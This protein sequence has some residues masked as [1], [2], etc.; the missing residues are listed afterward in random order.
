MELPKVSEESFTE[1]KGIIRVEAVTNDARCIWRETPLRDVGIDGQI[2][3]VND[4][5]RATGRIV[6]TQVKSG[7]SYFR[8]ATDDYVPYY[9]EDKHRNYWG[10]AP[11]PV[12]LVLHNPEEPET[13][14]VDVRREIQEGRHSPV[15]VLRSSVFDA[16]AVKRALAWDGAPLPVDPQPPDVLMR[17]MLAARNEEAAFPLSF[18]DLFVNGLT[19]L[20][21]SLYFG[22]D[23]ATEI[24]DAKLAIQEAEFG[25]GM[26]GPEYAFL[27]RYVAFLVANDLARVDFDWYRQTLEERDMVA[28]LLGPLTPRGRAL[29]ERIVALDHSRGIERGI[30]DQVVVERII[31]MVWLHDVLP[32]TKFIENFKRWLDESTG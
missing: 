26:A 4:N 8:D 12:I 19:D 27:D 1:R 20:G 30:Y 7:A 29:V 17:E 24:V 16:A 31:N 10:H 5:N 2:E 3:H 22:M 32:R 28:K 14:W 13:V 15:R 11:L 23:L 25:L 18:F 21:R 9:P 6:L